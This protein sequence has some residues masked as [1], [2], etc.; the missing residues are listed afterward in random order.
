MTHPQIGRALRLMNME[1]NG[2]PTVAE[3]EALLTDQGRMDTFVELLQRP[4]AGGQITGYPNLLQALTS[5]E[6]GRALALSNASAMRAA[7]G[8][9]SVMLEFIS[10]Q[11]ALDAIFSRQDVAAEFISSSA[12]AIASVP[13]MTSYTTPAGVVSASSLSGPYLPWWAFDDA[14]GTWWSAG[15]SANQWIQYE[16]AEPVF[17]HTVTARTYAV[18]YSPRNCRV[19][20]SANGVDF[21]TAATALF[22]PGTTN[23]VRAARAGFH[24]YWRLFA[25]DSY[26]A[27][28]GASLYDLDFTGFISP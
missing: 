22:L 19:E 2:A 1:K 5:T 16:F 24:K 21:V 18:P 12:L 17:I 4:G 13:N 11:S 6:A 9:Q 26:G 25:V 27:S 7:A 3:F 14:P 20:C 10:S 23:T 28:A 8:S 15:V